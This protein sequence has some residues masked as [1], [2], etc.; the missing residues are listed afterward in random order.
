MTIFKGGHRSSAKQGIGWQQPDQYLNE[1]SSGQWP[2]F[3][4]WQKAE[5]PS[6][7]LLQ[8]EARHQRR[9]G[10]IDPASKKQQQRQQQVVIITRA[11]CAPDALPS[12]VSR[13][14]RTGGGAKKKGEA[15]GVSAAVL[16]PTASATLSILQV[17]SGL[18]SCCVL[19]IETGARPKQ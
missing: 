5:R 2:H 19:R 11:G 4:V 12:E 3:G 7:L 9:E 8:V 17:F 1:L 15:G 6:V 18:G 10:V 16:R 13:P 14:P